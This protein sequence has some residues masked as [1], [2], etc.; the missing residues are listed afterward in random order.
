MEKLV[1][2]TEKTSFNKMTAHAIKSFTPFCCILG[3][4]FGP[5]TAESREPKCSLFWGGQ[6]GLGAQFAKNHFN[7]LF[8]IY[9][10]HL[11]T[12]D[13]RFAPLN[14]FLSRAFNFSSL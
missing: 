8:P 10:T 5:Q 12:V 1:V 9:H 11:R 6:L 4:I 14:I 2:T 3:I 13:K 7:N